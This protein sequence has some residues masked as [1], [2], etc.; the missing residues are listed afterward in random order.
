MPLPGRYDNGVFGI[1]PVSGDPPVVLE[2][3]QHHAVLVDGQAVRAIRA[4][5]DM[6][7]LGAPFRDVQAQLG[8][9]LRAEGGAGWS[10]DVR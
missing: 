8:E 9:L 4:Q 3:E 7:L 10:D 5:S 1:G 2:A 6:D